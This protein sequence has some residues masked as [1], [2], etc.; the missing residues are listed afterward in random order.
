[1]NEYTIF[2]IGDSA[3]TIDF[4]N[5][6]SESLN[7]KVMAMQS[8]LHQNSF[9]GLVDI[10]IAYS[11]LSIIYDPAVLA[12]KNNISKPV[13]EFVKQKL[14]DAYHLS[15]VQERDR[16]VK[17]IPVCYDESFGPDLG[18]ISSEKQIKMDEIVYLHTSITYRVYMIGFQPGFPYMASVNERIAIPRKDKPR[19]LVAAGSVGLAG[20]QTGVYPL[21][22]PGG[23]QIIGRTPFKLFDKTK[24]N[25]LIM[26]PGDQVQFYPV[27]MKEFSRLSNRRS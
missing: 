8:W 24:P 26:K 16:I 9:E 15:S 14:T 6:I 27:T 5:Y 23:W 10:I 17:R 25:L 21:D 19:Q 18:F 4:G 13:F 1:M 12:S 20:I 2:A 11:S 7:K 22:S 3:I